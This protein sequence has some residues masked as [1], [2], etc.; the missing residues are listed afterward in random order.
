MTEIDIDLDD[1]ATVDLW[2]AVGELA[3]RLPGQWALIGGLMVQLHAL[4]HGVG[5]VRLTGDIDVLGQ[6]RPPG[7]LRSIDTAL[8]CEGFELVGPDLDGYGYR[9]ERA[10]LIVD[11][12][13]PDGINPPPDLGAGVKAI[14]VPGGSQ[15][16]SRSEPVTVTV[17]GRSFAVRRPTLLGAVLIKARSLMVHSDPESQRE[18]LLQLLALI[19]DPRQMAG[20]LRKTERRWLQAVEPQLNFSGLSLLDSEPMRRAV[21]AYRLLSRNP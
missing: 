11:L 6:A 10:G 4:E 13:A 21:L 9:Y 17:K 14:G 7:A 8:R 20:E 1:Q 12:L 3:E 19:E 2:A 16:L 18:D 5:D 15:A